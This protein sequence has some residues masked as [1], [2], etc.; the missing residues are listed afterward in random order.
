MFA[1]LQKG[2]LLWLGSLEKLSITF[3]LYELLVREG[4]QINTPK[5][6]EFLF[7]ESGE[8][9]CERV[10]YGIARCLDPMGDN[11][12]PLSQQYLW[13]EVYEDSK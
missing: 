7:R 5:T 12:F 1:G 11:Y 10:E 8:S 4:N 2:L 6:N 3:A 13:D 9:V